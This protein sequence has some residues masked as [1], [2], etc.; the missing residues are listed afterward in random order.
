LNGESF[1]GGRVRRVGA[2]LG[3]RA[4]PP[5]REFLV[6]GRQGGTKRRK[7]ERKKIARMK[8]TLER[9]V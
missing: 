1:E 2:R 3:P 6:E 5:T 8:G 7:N 4:T 9:L